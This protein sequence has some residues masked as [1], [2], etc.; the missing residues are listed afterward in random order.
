MQGVFGSALDKFPWHIYH[1]YWSSSYVDKLTPEVISA[2][3]DISKSYIFKLNILSFMDFNIFLRWYET[4][5]AKVIPLSFLMIE[6]WG[7]KVKEI[8]ID[9]NAYIHRSS[10]FIIGLM[11]GWPDPSLEEIALN[12][13]KEKTNLLR[14]LEGVKKITYSNYLYKSE[15]SEDI[16]KDQYGA[17]YERLQKLKDKYD[18]ENIFCRSSNLVPSTKGK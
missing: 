9:N 14:K 15:I 3:V 18:P 8:P 10:D 7:G 16:L 13:T 4:E 6:L 11:I 5:M 1:S 12:W 2:F 17:R